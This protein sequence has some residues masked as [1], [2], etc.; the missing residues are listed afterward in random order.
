VLAG[1]HLLLIAEVLSGPHVAKAGAPLVR[2]RG[3][4]PALAAGA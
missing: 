2:L 4:Y 3:S 1:D